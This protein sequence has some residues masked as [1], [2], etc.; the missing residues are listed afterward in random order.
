MTSFL[1][2]HGDEYYFKSQRNRISLQSSFSV[3]E[4]F[5]P[6]TTQKRSVSSLCLVVHQFF[7]MSPL[8]LHSGESVA[9]LNIT[10]FTKC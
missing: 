4:G 8:R 9:L 10:S 1:E 2:K 3:R 5:L 7:L 6:P